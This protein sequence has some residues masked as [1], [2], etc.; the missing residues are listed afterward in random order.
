MKVVSILC[1][2]V[3]AFQ[4]LAVCAVPMNTVKANKIALAPQA[5]Q[6]NLFDPTTFFD[7]N[8][9]L[10][11]A[12]FLAAFNPLTFFPAP[13]AG[14]AGA[15]LDF[16]ALLNLFNPATFLNPAN[17][18]PMPPAAAAPTPAAEA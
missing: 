8:N 7:P 18:F 13:Q 14:G 1:G 5:K 12:N 6:L 15:P 17:F 11:P 4:M 10:N 9:F 16:N 2:L 3:L